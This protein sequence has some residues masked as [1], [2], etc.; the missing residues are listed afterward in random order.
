MGL[1][2]GGTFALYSL[3]CRHAKLGLLPNHQAADEEL[4][5]YFSP[6][7][8]S[9]NIPPSGFRSYIEKHKNTRTGLL[10]VVL[11]AASMVIAVGAIS[12]SISGS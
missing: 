3:L 12:P 2:T 10:L 9:R 4:S 6:G 5:T 11:F 8:S 1:L 7:Y